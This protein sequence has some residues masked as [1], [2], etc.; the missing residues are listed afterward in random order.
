MIRPAQIVALALVL[1]F[2]AAVPMTFAS[3]PAPAEQ[4]EKKDAGSPKA[5]D[6]KNEKKDAGGK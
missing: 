3:E 5:D 2:G 6:Q 4:K 1:A